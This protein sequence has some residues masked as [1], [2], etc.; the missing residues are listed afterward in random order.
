MFDKPPL[1]R[2]DQLPRKAYMVNVY[3]GICFVIALICCLIY[4]VNNYND[5]AERKIDVAN[6]LATLRQE[7][8]AD[9]IAAMT[10]LEATADDS[11][12]NAFINDEIMARADVRGREIDELV[13]LLDK[14][15]K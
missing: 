12:V 11:C 7:A 6:R 8:T 5:L 9:S 10:L 14:L 13:V 2:F 1:I 4:M 3:C 15:I